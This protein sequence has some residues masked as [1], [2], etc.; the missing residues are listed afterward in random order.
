VYVP[1]LG[2]TSAVQGDTAQCSFFPRDVLEADFA[3]WP[4]VVVVECSA[5]LGRGGGRAGGLFGGASGGGGGKHD[6]RR[7]SESDGGSGS[8]RDR[9]GGL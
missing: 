1:A 5:R 9:R 8:K 4:Y 3:T 7:D 6:N 2:S